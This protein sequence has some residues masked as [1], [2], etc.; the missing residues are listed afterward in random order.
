MLKNFLAKLAESWLAIVAFGVI[1]LFIFALYGLWQ[2]AHSPTAHYNIQL[3]WTG[4]TTITTSSV[5][6]IG[7]GLSGITSEARNWM[8]AHAET[9]RSKG[10]D[11]K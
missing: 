10:A 1:I 3:M 6:A 2:N 8:N 5:L 11:P 7:P 4:I 9:L